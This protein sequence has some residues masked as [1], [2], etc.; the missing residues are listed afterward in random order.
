MAGDG[1]F[2]VQAPSNDLC[3]EGH[4]ASARQLWLLYPAIPEEPDPM[5]P[6]RR[7][8]SPPAGLEHRLPGLDGVVPEH[9]P[10][11]LRWRGPYC[12]LRSHWCDVLVTSDSCIHHYV[13]G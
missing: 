6:H 2:G 13:V 8:A 9:P 1:V 4:W 10:L 3:R 7:G 5:S 11:G 12:P